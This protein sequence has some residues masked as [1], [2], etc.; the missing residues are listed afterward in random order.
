MFSMLVYGA[1]AAV[2][3]IGYAF[4]YAPVA[5]GLAA[6]AGT[7][8]GGVASLTV[9]NLA[10]KAPPDKFEREWLENQRMFNELVA[11]RKML[12]REEAAIRRCKGCGVSIE[13]RRAN[14]K[15]CGDACR[16]R[17]G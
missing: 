5:S 17:G 13:H 11:E 12:E 1:Y 15:W 9:L 7:V 14:A 4:T 16:R 6:A 8:A 10:S 2:A 3:S